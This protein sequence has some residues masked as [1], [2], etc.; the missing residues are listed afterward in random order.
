MGVDR[1]S[2]NTSKL[3]K[4]PWALWRERTQVKC[5][6]KSEKNNALKESL[7]LET[8]IWAPIDDIIQESSGDDNSGWVMT[9]QGSSDAA[10]ESGKESSACIPLAG[11]L[12]QNIL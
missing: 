6:E 12:L 11:K 3:Q 7:L 2:S 10:P 5:R 8:W 9:R 1:V 4:D